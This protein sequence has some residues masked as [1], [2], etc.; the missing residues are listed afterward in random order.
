MKRIY[1]VLGFILAISLIVSTASAYDTCTGGIITHS[2]NLTFSGT[3]YEFNDTEVCQHGCSETAA[4]MY[5]CN[6]AALFVPLSFYLMLE[7][8]AF[9]FMVG[10][11][12]RKE[13][14][15]C[16]LGLMLFFTLSLLSF[17]VDGVTLS[18]AAYL[19]MGMGL[20]S[21]VYTVIL[22][23]TPLQDLAAEKYKA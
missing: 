2:F 19:N 4:G 16:I 1:P 20:F 18:W 8:M 12:V 9:I 13:L 21:L 3:E 14:I 10:A 7:I 17:N 22:W 11:I 6:D 15:W 5:R 23:F